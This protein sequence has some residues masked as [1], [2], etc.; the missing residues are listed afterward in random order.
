[1][2]DIIDDIAAAAAQDDKLRVCS[3]VVIQMADTF[4]LDF[5]SFFSVINGEEA[6]GGVLT[7]HLNAMYQVENI[8]TF[9][10]IQFS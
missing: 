3:R 10:N 4:C 6:D 9:N 8:S 2:R 5:V 1:M 7:F